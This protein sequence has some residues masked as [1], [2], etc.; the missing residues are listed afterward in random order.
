MPGDGWQQFANLRAYYAFMYAHPGK[1][2]TFMGNEIAQHREWNHDQSLD[3]HLLEHLP[4]KGIQRLVRDL[5]ILYRDTRALH[6]L[7]SSPDGFEWIDWNDSDNSVLS[8]LRK[9]SAGAF[10]VAVT[11]LTPIVRDD[12][13]LGVPLD[14]EYVELLNTDD[15]CYGGSGLTND[16]AQAE[17]D[18]HHGRPYSIHLRLPPLATIF[19][20]PRETPTNGA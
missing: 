6:E 16:A 2:L 7:D 8:W 3:W 4:H 19:L 14:G 10:V 18:E 20:I 11:N 1:K 15:E 12:Y 17:S 9:D 13:Q 5:N